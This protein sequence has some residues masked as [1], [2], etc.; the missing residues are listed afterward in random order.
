MALTEQEKANIERIRKAKLRKGSSSYIQVRDSDLYDWDTTRRAVLMNIAFME[1]T[2]EKNILKYVEGSPFLDPMDYLG[3]CVASQRFLANATG[4]TENYVSKCVQLFK[5]DGVIEVRHWTGLNGHIHDEYRLNADVVQAH[6]RPANYMQYERKRPRRGGNKAANKG[7]FKTG[8]GRSRGPKPH[9]LTAI[10]T[11][12]ESHLPLSPTANSHIPS[13]P[14]SPHS[15]TANSEMA[16]N[17]RKGVNPKRGGDSNSKGEGLGG[18]HEGRGHI[19]SA[20]EAQRE[21]ENGLSATSQSKPSRPTGGYKTPIPNWKRFPHLFKVGVD[22][23]EYGNWNGGR[24]PRCKKCQGILP[25]R[26]HHGDDCDFVPQ[27]DDRDME[28]REGRVDEL[29]K[30]KL[31]QMAERRSQEYILSEFGAEEVQD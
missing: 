5:E 26:E 27:Y 9:S 28:M 29:R 16:A 1:C 22:V 8:D 15:L 2:E 25:P 14:S 4:T 7:A 30:D 20:A 24:L 19:A 13:Q 11:F 10:P 18:A 21:Q 6:K 31:E 12:P 17:A 3:W 23:D